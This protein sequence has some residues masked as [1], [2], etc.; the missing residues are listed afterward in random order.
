MSDWRELY[1]K[2]KRPGIGELSAFLPPDVTELFR[3]FANHMSRVCGIGCAPAVH[4]VTHGWVFRFGRYNLF[5]LTVR[6]S[7]GAFC[8]DHLR[9]SD[10]ITLMEAIA[11]AEALHAGGYRDKLAAYAAEKVALQAA[12]AKKRVERE[13]K[14][15]GEMAGSIDKANFNRFSWSPK[16]PRAK[17]ARL[18]ESDA[19]MLPDEELADDI[20]FT[21]YARCLQGRDERLLHEK[22]KLSCHGCGAVL[23]GKRGLMECACGR[24]YL[25]RDCARSFRAN[26]M[27]SGAASHIFGAFID[28]WPRAT[29]YAE[30]MRL[31]DG[32]IHEF[33]INLRSGVKGR[34]VGINLIEGTKKQIA[35]LILSLAGSEWNQDTK[36]TFE[37]NLK[38]A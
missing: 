30:K 33:H 3:E 24:Q 8:V 27:P 19:R 5:M 11:Y 36:A 2:K 14:E 7:D 18:Y 10:R 1:D 29:R 35:D 12:T 25:F 4:T 23:Q 38:R 26:N 34:F 21:L 16:V 6:I 9:V 20:G 32:L 13:Q 37:S 22:G 15:I 17:L 31:I 28:D